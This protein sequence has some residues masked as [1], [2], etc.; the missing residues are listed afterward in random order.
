MASLPNAH[1]VQKSFI[2][3]HMAVQW[4]GHIWKGRQWE[5]IA[6]HYNINRLSL[7]QQDG[8]GEAGR[9]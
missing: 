2:D 1:A 5:T 6:L 9:L 4:Q 8:L 3:E 7:C